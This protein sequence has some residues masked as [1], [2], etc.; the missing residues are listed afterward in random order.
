MIR[1]LAL[2][3]ALFV[4][5]GSA[6]PSMAVADSSISGLDISASVSNNCTISAAGLSFGTYNPVEGRSVTGTVTT[7]CN[8]YAT[9]VIKLDQGMNSA[10]GSSST[11]PLRRLRNDSNTN[12]LSYTLY[13]NSGKTTIWG[14]STETG[15]TVTGT[16]SSKSTSVYGEIPAGQTAPSGTYTDTVTA[17]VTY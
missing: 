17:T 1:R 11:A 10:T 4:A 15:V 16:G 12:Y 8:L 6:A 7:N 9:A 3:S 2:A 13:Q 5:V 14:N